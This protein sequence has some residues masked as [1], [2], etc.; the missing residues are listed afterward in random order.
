M[1]TSFRPIRA[2]ENIG[3]IIRINNLAKRTKQGLRQGM[4]KVGQALVS[5]ANREILKG[6]K[7]G[8]IYFIKFRGQGRGKRRFAHQSS[9]PGE[10]HANLFGDLRR[11]LSY[12]LRGSTEIEFG[13]GVSSGENAPPYA[14]ALEF[15]INTKDKRIKPRPTLKNAIKSEQGNL[16]QHFENG[17]MDKI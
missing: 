17:I 4:F 5:E 6:K 1:T 14:R 8:R 16:V 11:S 10:T 2:H 12:K 9:A 3:T 15:G 7:T 13:Y